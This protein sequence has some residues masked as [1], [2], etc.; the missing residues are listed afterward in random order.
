[1]LALWEKQDNFIPDIIIID[2]ADIL[3]A[4]ADCLKMDLRNQQNKIWQRLRRLSQEKHC[5]VVT[6][7]QADAA[8]FESRTLKL[9][10]FSEDKRKFGHCTSMYGI[11]QDDPEEKE[12][13]V[14]RLNELVIREGASST[15][16]QVRLLQCLEMGRPFLGSYL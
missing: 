12:L 14:M 10:N 4:D 8:S 6:A 1:L 11:N 16:R 7:T 13:R 2:Y 5:L 3:L 15:F 9:H